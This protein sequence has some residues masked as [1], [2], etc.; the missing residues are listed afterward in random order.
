MRARAGLQTAEVV[1]VDISND[2]ALEARFGRSIPVF[3]VGEDQSELVTSQRQVREFLDR[4]LSD[5]G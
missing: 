1:R 2:P 4:V 3:A 5:S